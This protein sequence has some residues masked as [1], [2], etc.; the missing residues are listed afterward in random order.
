MTQ[1]HSNNWDKLKAPA[2]PT[3]SVIDIYKSLIPDGDIFLLGVTPE[4]ANSYDSVIAVDRDIKM[5]E[6]VWPGDTDTK[7]AT[8]SSWETFLTSKKFDGIIGDVALTLLADKKSITT[9]NKKTFDMLKSGGTV[10]QRIFHKPKEIITRN[11]LIDML[12]KPATV[13]FNAFKWMMFMCYAEETHSKI[14]L[15]NIL[16]LFNQI[17]PIREI[18]AKDT[19]W[20]IDDINTID[21]YKDSDWEV[22]VMSKK[23][24]LETVPKGSIKVQFTYNDDYDLAELCPILSY[25]KPV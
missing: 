17:C 20:S 7:S 13:N 23:E 18:A 11:M 14:K 9:F 3:Q 6:K 8:N 4:I 5:I 12:S 2:R 25:G 19:G 10:A 24:W 15:S 16:K 21:L 1:N 22:I